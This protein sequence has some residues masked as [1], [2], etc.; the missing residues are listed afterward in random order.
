MSENQ[1]EQTQQEACCAFYNTFIAPRVE[2]MYEE[3]EEC[4]DILL[5]FLHKQKMTFDD[6]YHDI[7]DY[8]LGFGLEYIRELEGIFPYI[9]LDD[10][11]LDS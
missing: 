8:S 7:L 11:S 5:Q 10:V 2:R 9:E 3:Q 1:T 6:F 4:A